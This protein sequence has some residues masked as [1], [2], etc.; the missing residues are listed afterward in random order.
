MFF[1]KNYKIPM[2]SR[3]WPLRPYFPEF[4]KIAN[5]HDNI[6]FKEIRKLRKSKFLKKS[7][8][9]LGGGLIPLRKIEKGDLLDYSLDFPY[10]QCP[11]PRLH[12]DF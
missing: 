10:D 11:P 6:D 12:G 8:C 5:L 2:Q 7:P 1:E 9:N 3:G 4:R